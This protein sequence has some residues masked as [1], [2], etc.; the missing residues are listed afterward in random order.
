MIKQISLRIEG[1][2]ATGAGC[3]DSLPVN[4]IRT[5]AGSENSAYAC[6]CIWRV[7]ADVSLLVHLDLTPEY[8]GTRLMADRE[9]KSLD[10]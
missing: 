4:R 10:L 7:R 6:R 2:A 9:E 3:T 8:V 5:V 1:G